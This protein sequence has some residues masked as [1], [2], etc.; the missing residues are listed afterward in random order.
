MEYRSTLY[1]SPL[2]YNG[3]H[4]FEVKMSCPYSMK[5]T[6]HTSGRICI[7]EVYAKHKI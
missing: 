1:N 5:N 7:G 4:I 2:A 3:K 6:V